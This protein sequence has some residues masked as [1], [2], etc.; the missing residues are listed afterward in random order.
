MNPNTEDPCANDPAGGASRS[1]RVLVTILLAWLAM[2]GFDFLLHAGLLARLYL[3]PRPFLLAPLES[4]RRL[5]FGYLSFLLSAILLVWL[6]ARLRLFGWRAGLGFGL[7]LGALIWGAGTLG[8]YSISTA[9]ASLLAG[10]FLGQTV[11]FG[12]AGAVAG[13]GLAGGRLGRLSVKVVALVLFLVIV[14]VA[15]QSFGLAPAA[16]RLLQ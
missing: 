11:E 3:E 15:L 5:P 13:S 9:D 6:M 4:F 7:K 1:R 10:W 14:T 12:V 8:L 2:L 16:G